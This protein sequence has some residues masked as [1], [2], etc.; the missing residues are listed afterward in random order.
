MRSVIPRLV[1]GS[2]LATMNPDIQAKARVVTPKLPATLRAP[3]IVEASQASVVNVIEKVRE[4]TDEI[5]RRVKRL[6][7]EID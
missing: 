6:I 5:E 2:P 7:N 4:I 3:R 1:S